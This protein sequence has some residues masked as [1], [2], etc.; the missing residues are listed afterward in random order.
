MAFLSLVAAALLAAQ[1]TP[2]LPSPQRALVQ[3]TASVRIL[4]GERVSADKIP[5]AAIVRD[6]KV[7]GADGSEKPARLVEFP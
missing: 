1:A 5:E 3:A 7:R 2:P 4:S 6:T